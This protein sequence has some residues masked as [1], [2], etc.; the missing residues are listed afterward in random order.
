MKTLRNA[1][2]LG[3]STDLKWLVYD[4][5]EYT[6]TA[7]TT[8]GETVEV[9]PHEVADHYADDDGQSI[10]DFRLTHKIDQVTMSLKSKKSPPT[11]K[12]S[13]KATAPEKKEGKKAEAKTQ[14]VVDSPVVVP[15]V[16]V[17]QVATEHFASRELFVLVD[18]TSDFRMEVDGTEDDA[19]KALSEHSRRHPML[20]VQKRVIRQYDE[21]VDVYTILRVKDAHGKLVHECDYDSHD[22]AVKDSAYYAKKGLDVSL[23]RVVEAII[24]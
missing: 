1:F 20:F 11:H 23:Y 5:D 18:P 21:V 6:G 8:T 16:A 24:Q 3:Y 15:E 10:D 2:R 22:V 4:N 12:T 17:E 19:K 13:N 7:I 14:R 9:E